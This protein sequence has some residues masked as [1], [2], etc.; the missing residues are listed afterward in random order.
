MRLLMLLTQ[1]PQ[2]PAVAPSRQ[3]QKGCVQ[4]SGL[5]QG[6]DLRGSDEAVRV[7]GLGQRGISAAARL[8]SELQPGHTS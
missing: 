7:V 6:P 5:A 8:M 3:Q 2:G 4:Q 1:S